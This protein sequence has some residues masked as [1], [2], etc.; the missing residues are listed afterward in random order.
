[1]PSK[2]L[3]G[4]HLGYS[5]SLNNNKIFEEQHEG[6]SQTELIRASMYSSKQGN[7]TVW[8]E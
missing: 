4:K 6:L 5:L 2:V 7:L 3:P 1:M 8:F